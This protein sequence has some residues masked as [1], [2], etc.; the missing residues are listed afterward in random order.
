MPTEDRGPNGADGRAEY[1]PP[2][3]VAL[4]VSLYQVLCICVCVWKEENMI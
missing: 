3:S 2:I 4:I 1:D